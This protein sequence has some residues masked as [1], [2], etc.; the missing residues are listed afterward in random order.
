MKERDEFLAHV[1]WTGMKRAPGYGTAAYR[2]KAQSRAWDVLPFTRFRIVLEE[3][4]IVGSYV[5]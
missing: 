5:G 4:L 2:K 3:F 1:L